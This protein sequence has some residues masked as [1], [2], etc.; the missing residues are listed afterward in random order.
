MQV[1]FGLSAAALFVPVLYHQAAPLTT[2][3]T[4]AE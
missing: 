4:A 2:K 3:D 1:V